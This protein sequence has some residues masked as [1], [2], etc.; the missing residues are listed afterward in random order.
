M[1]SD[2][3][4]ERTVRLPGALM[5]ERPRPERIRTHPAAWRLAV[6]TVCFGA[7]MGQLDA[8]I[9]SLTYADLRTG[10]GA[11]LTAVT[12]VSLAYLLTLVALLLPAG[13]ISD[14]HGR[15]LLYLYGFVVFTAASAGCALAPTLPVLIALRVVQAAGAALM[16]ANSVALVATSAPPGRLRAALGVQATAQALGLALGPLAGGALVTT[17]G[18]R[19]IFALNVPVGLVAVVA[20]HF[21][22]PRTRQRHVTPGFDLRGTALL[23]L[24][25][26]S[27]LLALSALSAAP[28]PHRP[29]AAALLVAAG[30][31]AGFVRRQRRATHPL[32]PPELL[33][34]RPVRAGLAGALCGYLVLFGPMV[35][36]PLVLIAHGTDALGAG[37]VLVWLPAGFATAAA[38]ADRTLPRGWSPRARCLLGAGLVLAALA[39]L[40]VLP[41][42][43]ATLPPAL[44]LLG[45]GLGVFLPANNAVIMAAVPARCSGTGGGLVNMARATG[46]ALGVALVTLALRLPGTG[47]RT[48]HGPVLVLLAS[49]AVALAATVRTPPTR[50]L[51]RRGRRAA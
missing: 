40:Y 10:F 39:A 45:L 2:V 44:V 11:S 36:V 34:P 43:A 30:A 35:L 31:G 1:P 50:P 37:L 26:T 41:F 7:F 21:L 49:A 3:R 38:T 6:A 22:L 46:S 25:T 13:R 20:G 9:V 12:W 17:L 33:R 19:W 27:A 29:A 47:A 5:R 16:Q 8:G 15:K 48:P 4:A 18:W 14:A 32:L 51:P 28:A 42:T 24:A 23:A